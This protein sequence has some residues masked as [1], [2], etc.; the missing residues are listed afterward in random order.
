MTKREHQTLGKKVSIRPGVGFYALIP[1][2]RYKAWFALGEMVD[3]SIQSFEVNRARLHAVHGPHFKLRIEI[4]FGTSPAPYIRISDNAAGIAESDFDRA[5]EPAAPPIDKT[6]I[7]QYGIGMKSSA[8]WFSKNFTITTKALDETMEHKVHFDIAKILQ[9]ADDDLDVESKEKDPN[10]HGTIIELRDLNQPIPTGTSLGLT[11]KY[12]R[13]IYREWLRSGEVNLIVGGERLTYEPPTW[14]KEP[15]WP[16]DQGPQDGEVIEWI[17]EIDLELRDSWLLDSNVDKP[18]QPP[19]ITGYVAILEKGST[20]SAGIS[21]MW[22][23]KVVQGAGAAADSS[24]DLYRPI[25]IFGTGNSFEKQRIFGELD[26]SE[27]RV[28]AFK[29][30]INWAANQEEEF[31][32]KLLSQINSQDFPLKRMAQHYRVNLSSSKI[33]KKIEG[34]LDSTAQSMVVSLIPEDLT[35]QEYGGPIPVFPVIAEDSISEEALVMAS[36]E[37]ILRPIFDSDI[38]IEIIEDKTDPAW[39]RVM[40]ENQLWRVT[41]NREHPFMRSFAGSAADEFEP[42][43]R[44]ATAIGY[45]EITGKRSGRTDVDFIR[46]QI[47]SLLKSKFASKASIKPESN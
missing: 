29:D 43:I 12:L 6:G 31:L 19:R 10:D 27:L 40:S 18:N 14:L 1:A 3:N 4:S 46:N 36:A 35:N 32:E 42:I 11:R 17:K 22:K 26:V 30:A 34:V 16:S 44:I 37:A 47:N 41:I 5:F 28:T 2:L 21:L 7:S 33:K 13:S 15:Y 38:R 23:R 25:Q 8:C 9:N 45:A 24:D 39:L 20:T